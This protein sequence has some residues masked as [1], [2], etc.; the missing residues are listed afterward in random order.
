MKWRRYSG[1]ILRV[2]AVEA[3]E[4][5][6][7]QSEESG[8]KADILRD[9]PGSLFHHGYLIPRGKNSL[10][11]VPEIFSAASSIPR[12]HFLPGNGRSERLFTVLREFDFDLAIG[13]REFLRLQRGEAF[14]RPFL[15]RLRVVPAFEF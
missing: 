14:G 3:F 9:M 7:V 10:S 5:K 15:L 12:R 2:F 11:S 6:F 4:E 13:L 8:V 1:A